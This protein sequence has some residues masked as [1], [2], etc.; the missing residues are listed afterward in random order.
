MDEVKNPSETTKPNLGGRPLGSRSKISQQQLRDA[1]EMFL[2]ML[3]RVKSMI[4]THLDSHQELA[5]LL[6]IIGTKSGDCATC[7]HYITIILEYSFGKPPQR[8]QVEIGEAREEAQ[9]MADELDLEDEGQRKEVVEMALRL[10][11]EGRE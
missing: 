6:S 8:L 7:R 3:D 4:E 9:R 11:T 1:R 5:E 2:P 10:L